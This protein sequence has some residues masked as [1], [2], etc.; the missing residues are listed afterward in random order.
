MKVLKESSN[1]ARCMGER[2]C[3][4]YQDSSSPTPTNPPPARAPSLAKILAEQRGSNILSIPFHSI[5]KSRAALYSGEHGSP[6][7]G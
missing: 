7:S 2:R 6:A 3:L 4:T 1:F 5:S